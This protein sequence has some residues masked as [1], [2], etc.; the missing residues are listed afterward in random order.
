MMSVYGGSLPKFIEYVAESAAWNDDLVDFYVFHVVD[1]DDLARIPRVDPTDPDSPAA[2]AKW[3]CAFFW[4]VSNESC[5]RSHDDFGAIS[6]PVSCCACSSEFRN[7]ARARCILLQCE[8]LSHPPRLF[9]SS[10]PRPFTLALH[11]H[12]AKHR[13]C[14]TILLSCG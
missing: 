7:L 8:C 6:P 12:D 13:I 4:G 9:P 2:P 14:A 1:A 11:K 3:V 10:D 5:T